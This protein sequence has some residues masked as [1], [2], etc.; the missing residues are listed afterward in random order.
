[1]LQQPSS[2]LH[3][4]LLGQV[5]DLS[6]TPM[7]LSHLHSAELLLVNPALLRLWG[8]DA[9][10][11]LGRS[12]ADNGLWHRPDDH[13]RLLQQVRREGSV[14]E[15]ACQWAISQGYQLV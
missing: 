1:M 10:T 5:F 6:P 15:F 3:S 13:Q 14:A 8:Q 9:P 2:A 4:A 11:L 12:A 7:S